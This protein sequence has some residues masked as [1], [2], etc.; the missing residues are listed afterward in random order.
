MRETFALAVTALSAGRPPREIAVRLIVAVAMAFVAWLAGCAFLLMEPTPPHA[1]K[2]RQN[3]ATAFCGPDCLK[4]SDQASYALL[5][6][7]NRPFAGQARLTN[8][9]NVRHA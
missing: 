7:L 8:R 9:E 2:A 5:N 4:T 3:A 1:A 6:P